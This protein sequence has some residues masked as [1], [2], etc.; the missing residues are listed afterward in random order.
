MTGYIVFD[1]AGE[2][3]GP[4]PVGSSVT[5]LKHARFLL[6]VLC[7]LRASSPA[8]AGESD[9]AQSRGAGT[10]IPWRIALVGAGSGA[11]VVAAHLQNYDSWW[12][13]NRGPFHLSVDDAPPLGADKCGHFLFS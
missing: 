5:P 1:S 7:A 3:I 13:G 11:L 10:L 2:Y 9:T 6:S 4:R 8:H 12:K